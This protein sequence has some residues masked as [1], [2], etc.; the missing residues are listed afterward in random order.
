MT[1]TEKIEY[2]LTTRHY[3]VASSFGGSA[4]NA[5]RASYTAGRLAQSI[6]PHPKSSEDALVVL[7]TSFVSATLWKLSV[8]ILL[9]ILT[10][11]TMV[12]LLLR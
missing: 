11:E 1:R 3:A 6:E 8:L 5:Q 4:R 12:S 7:S 2:F 10:S 9:L